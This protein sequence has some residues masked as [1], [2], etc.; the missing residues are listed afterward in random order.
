[1]RKQAG[2]C[3]GVADASAATAVLNSDGKDQIF[4]L[5]G[6]IHARYVRLDAN[7]GKRPDHAMAATVGYHDD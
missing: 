6:G 2:G 5:H 3:G 1:M 7:L 4:G